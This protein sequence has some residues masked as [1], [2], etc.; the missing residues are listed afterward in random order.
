MLRIQSVA[1][2]ADSFSFHVDKISLRCSR[3]LKTT[4]RQFC[5]KAEKELSQVKGIPYKNL[6]IGVPKELFPNERRVALV[7][8]AVQVKYE[9]SL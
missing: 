3:G 5:Q 4:G 9:L 8:A 2:V 1:L 6:T 7:P